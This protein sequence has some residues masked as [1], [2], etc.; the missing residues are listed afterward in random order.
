MTNKEELIGFRRD[1]YFSRALAMLTQEKGWWK[2]IVLCALAYLVPIVGP[3][4]VMGY[5]IEWSRR[6]SWGS[7]EAPSRHVKVGDLV[8]SGWRRFVVVFGWTLAALIV[9][10]ILP[11]IPLVGD[12]L[13]TVWG[14]VLIF[15]DVVFLVAAVRATIYQSFKAGYRVKTLWAMVSK[16]P[17]GLMRIWL[18]EFVISA[19]ENIVALIVLLPSLLGAIPYFIRLFEYIDSY[20]YYIDD[21]GAMSILFDAL[22]YLVGQIGG[23]VLAVIALSLVV[24]SFSSLLS[25]CCMGLW[26]RQFDVPSWGKEEDPLPAGVLEDEKPGLPESPVAPQEDEK[27]APPAEPDADAVEEEPAP[28]PDE[29]GGAP[30]EGDGVAAPEPASGSDEPTDEGGLPVD[31]DGQEGLLG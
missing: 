16:D 19:I 11:E 22:G 14:I 27:P 1:R 10:Q 28:E 25:C 20:Y 29:N 3:L 9:G 2:P 26:M 8:A 17:W 18:I 15:I 31:P 12:F 13:G 4:A 30:V 23:A 7:T 5:G 21:Y 24:K 6:V